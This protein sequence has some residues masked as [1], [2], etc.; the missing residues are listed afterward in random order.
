MFR[1]L[2]R[3]RR[4]ERGATAIEYGLIAGLISIV[5]ITTVQMVGSKLEAVFVYIVTTL[6]GSLN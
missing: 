3:L 6:G 4:D 5:I 2:R 1:L